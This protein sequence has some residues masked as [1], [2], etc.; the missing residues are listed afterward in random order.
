MPTALGVLLR[1]AA[2]GFVAGRRDRRERRL[3]IAGRDGAALQGGRSFARRLRPT[4]TATTACSPRRHLHDR[5]GRH[6]LRDA[7]AEVGAR[8]WRTRRDAR[9][10]RC[11]RAA[12]LSAAN[13]LEL[14]R[15]GG[16]AKHA[17][18]VLRN[19]GGSLAL[20]DHARRERRGQATLATTG[21]PKN[22]RPT[23][24]RHTR[25]DLYTAGSTPSRLVADGTGRRARV[26]RRHGLSP[27]VGRRLHGRRLALDVPRPQHRVHGRRHGAAGAAGRRPWAAIW[28][29]RHGHGPST[30][31]LPGRRGRRQRHLLLGSCD[32]ATSSTRSRARSRG[33]RSRSA[34]S[35]TA[36]TT[37][38]STS[39]AGTRASSTTSRACRTRTGAR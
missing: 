31:D 7:D 26:V 32:R 5:G 12:P 37:T 17:Q 39:A 20:A 14:H 4:R 38:P 34:V 19:T 1:A 6:E 28:P 29:A 36:R 11:A 24:A 22:L 18:L 35:P 23:N 15:A 30:A 2:S 8:P 21:S 3:P 25:K 10:S 27:G 9:T 33:R 16:R 13:T